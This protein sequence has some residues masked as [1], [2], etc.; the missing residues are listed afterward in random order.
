MSLLKRAYLRLRA[1]VGRGTLENEMQS[2]M[3]LHLERATERYMARGMSLDDARL[4]ARSEFGNRTALEEEGRDARGQR[5]IDALRGDLQF[6]FRY[7]ARRK[8]TVAIIVAVL[9]LGTGANTLVFSVYRGEF[10]KPALGVPD[11]PAHARFYSQVRATQTSTWENSL[12]TSA[13]LAALSERRDIFSDLAGWS[14]D[15][16]ILDG[17]AADSAD[18]HAVDGH[19]V[20]PSYF[21][22]V[23]L[24]LAAGQ[25]FTASG[26]APDMSAVMGYKM[27]ERLYGS[28]SAAVGRRIL[29]NETPVRV[30]GVAPKGYEG[31]YKGPDDATLWMPLSARS[32]V[33]RVDRRMLDQ[34]HSLAVLGRLA[35]GAT[36]EQATAFAQHV[37]T[38][39]LPDS[40]ARVGLARS[41]VVQ[42]MMAAPPGDDGQ[43]FIIATMAITGIGALILLVAW[44]NVSSLMVASAV[45]RR[46]EI[47]VRLSLGASRVRLLRQL[48]TESTLL[49]LG[50]GALGLT[51]GWWLLV[52]ITKSQGSD[53]GSMNVMPDGWTLLFVV[54]LSVVTGVIF[55][56]SPALHATR[57]GVSNALRD[58]GAATSTRSRLQRFFVGAQI[59]LSQPLLLFL[60]VILAMVVGGFTPHAPEMSKRVI[61]VGLS[62]LSKAGVP[63]QGFNA[64]DALIP[65][66]R[67]RPEVEGAVQDVTG[68][69]IRRF[70]AGDR[71]GVAAQAD[72]TPT[73]ITLEGT[74]PGWFAMVE[75]PIMLGRDVELA[76][77]I[78]AERNIVIGSDLAQRLW[79][80]ANP[81]GRRLA[82]PPIPGVNTDSATLTVVG[83]YDAT[84]AL[85]EMTWGGGGAGGDVLP[86]AYTAHGK[87]WRRDKILVRARGPGEPYLPE[88]NRVLRAEI[89][90]IPV[91]GVKTL[92]QVDREGFREV[93]QASIMAGT[94]GL[95][96]L[97]L[98]S[99]GL[100]GVVSLAVQQRTREIGIRIAIGARPGAV[101][102]M[103]LASG[104]RLT[105]VAMLIGLPLSVAGMKIGISQGIMIGPSVNVYLIGAA[106]A[107]ILLVV[108]AAATWVPARRASRVD[109][110]STLRAE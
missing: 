87:N 49:A 5:W 91:T 60:G 62:P 84:K 99:L 53:M 69:D 73:T 101:A 103:F 40:A 81:I 83:V 94:G 16:V 20:T 56:L 93:I 90:S 31:P 26:D 44:M 48:V 39:A 63:S 46:H 64:V 43:E 9:A 10:L 15:D 3:R 42:S 71:E 61:A 100:Y 82:A 21:R 41:A 37:V 23:G 30:V 72:S 4:A 110:A 57:V 65:R 97:L 77:T 18:P 35:P 7:F 108:A 68:F 58:S 89:P 96:A 102:R 47:A 55:G 34:I 95:M 59:A 11:D 27:A 107:A 19:F 36:H 54:A 85:P 22:T 32:E 74:A 92:E 33:L 1:I 6:A 8:V 66:L 38:T 12:F 104:V 67:A 25:G 45:A 79:G 13:E 51:L 106:I 17:Q 75:V 105:A 80:S 52:L 2:E 70:V 14:R 28:V 98:A 109:P 24:V 78:G 86:R 88:L 29:V 76:D 50:G